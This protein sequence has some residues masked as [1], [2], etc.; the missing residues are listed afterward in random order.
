MIATFQNQSFIFSLDWLQFSVNLASD[1]PEFV[2][3]EHIRIEFCQGNNIFEHRALVFNL[4]GEKLLTL[5]WKPYSSLLNSHLMTVQVANQSLYVQDGFG[6][7]WAWELLQEIVEC[8]FN[9][10]GRFDVC[11]DWVAD[12]IKLE[13]LRH[14]NSGHY[15]AQGKHE[16]SNWWHDT[17]TTDSHIRKQLH[18]LSW[19]S[20][21]S[22][23]KVKVYNKSREQGTLNG[24]IDDAEKPW[25]V[26]EWRAAN[27]PIDKVWRLEFSMSGAGQL[28][29]ENKPITL[30]EIASPQWV[31]NVFLSFYES[32]FVTRINQ[33]RRQGHHNNDKRVYLLNLPP[34]PAL[35]FW[36]KGKADKVDCP[37]AITLLRAMMR[38]MDNP[39]VLSNKPT[40]ETY[41]TAILDIVRLHKLEGYFYRTWQ[42]ESEEYF[43]SLYKSIGQGIHDTIKSPALLAE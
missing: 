7:K 16:G 35:L 5:L 25:I 26:N 9:A 39:S 24:N 37:P 42:T 23:I 14:L 38:Q 22:E 3:P 1:T 41:A 40:F 11:C 29:F 19:G 32:R 17:N 28:R 27:M 12:D 20:K 36:A 18:C 13:F 21:K 33:G 2:C 30:E 43:Q 31:C 15:Y 34:R 10:V 6:V 8:S 4:R